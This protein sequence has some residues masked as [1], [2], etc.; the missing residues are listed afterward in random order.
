MSGRNG[1]SKEVPRVLERERI[2]KGRIVELALEKI[3]LPDGSTTTLEI[4]RHP[5]AAAVVPFLDPPEEP[6]PRIVLIH[7]YRHAAGR[8]IYE[9]PAGIPAPGEE[10]QACA[11]RELEEETGYACGSLR[12]LTKLYTT[13]GF[14][15]E[16]IHLY[17]ASSLEPGFPS[18][19]RDEMIRLREVRRSEAVEMIRTG[20]LADAKSVAALL[21]AFF[22]SPEPGP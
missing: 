14:T 16:V 20:E 18:R 17:S 10:P 4:V 13:P 22:L 2:F 12:Y 21:H 5:G 15:D 6:D 7:Q 19:D 11:R 9:I 3:R 8:T 1:S